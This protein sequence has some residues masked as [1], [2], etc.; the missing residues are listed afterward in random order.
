MTKTKLTVPQVRQLKEQGKKVKMIVAYDY[1]FAALIDRSDADMILVGDSLG[2]VVLGYD[3][4]V[5]VNME[6]IIYH[7][8]AVRRAAPNTMVVADMPFMSYINVDEAIRNAGR[9]M[10]EGAD[11]VKL[12]G[13]LPMVDKV[14]GIVDAGIPVMAHIGLTPQTVSM[15]GG[16]KVQGKDAASA[17]RMLLEARELEGAGAFAVLLECV[18]APLARLITSKLS[19]STI[20]TGAGAGVDGHCLNAYDLTGIFERF[21]PKFVKQYAQ[22]GPQ[23]LDAFNAYCRE[24]DSGEFPGEKHCFTMKEEDLKRL[25]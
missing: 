7:L 1:P 9:L 15:L 4:T 5:P 24:I 13:G 2:M 6:E 14:K 22:V 23:M 3:T 18:P 20:G 8:R 10:K 17:E 11:C 16:F 25:Y 19:A 12:E 21:V